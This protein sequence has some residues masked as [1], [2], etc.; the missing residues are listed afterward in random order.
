MMPNS[1]T[2]ELW[3]TGTGIGE[4]EG[5][6]LVVSVFPYTSFSGHKISSIRA[7]HSVFYRK[8]VRD[9][10]RVHCTRVLYQYDGT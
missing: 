5:D 6:S 8:R 10:W 1:S 7:S 3:A 9:E 2:A 4:R